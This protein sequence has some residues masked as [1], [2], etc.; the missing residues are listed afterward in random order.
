MTHL[1][2]I[3]ILL[4]YAVYFIYLIQSK[5]SIQHLATITLLCIKLGIKKHK[6]YTHQYMYCALGSS[7]FTDLVHYLYE[8]INFIYVITLNVYFIAGFLGT[9]TAFETKNL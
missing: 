4:M 9:R 3:Y 1:K 2:N 8:I 6:S 5:C 7:Q